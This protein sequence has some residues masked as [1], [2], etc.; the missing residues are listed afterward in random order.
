[1][2][3]VQTAAADPRTDPYGVLPSSGDDPHPGPDT[4]PELPAHKAE[5]VQQPDHHAVRLPQVRKY[6]Y[7]HLVFTVYRRHKSLKVTGGV[8]E[9]Q[10]FRRYF[11]LDM[12]INF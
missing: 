5:P 10:E 3:S 11:D 12:V 1:M 9:L 6:T 2:F 7:F 8:Y 4:S